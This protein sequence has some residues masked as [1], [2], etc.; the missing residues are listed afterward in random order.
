MAKR[1]KSAAGSTGLPSRED[2][3]AFVSG[4]KRKVGKREIARAFGVQSG[5][6]VWLRQMLRALEDEGVLDRRRKSVHAAGRLPPVVV[7]DITGRDR[8]GE[9]VAEPEEWDA[10]A[11][12]LSAEELRAGS[13]VEVLRVEA[14]KVERKRV[15]IE[16]ETVEE[17]AAK[18]AEAIVAEGVLEG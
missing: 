1:P 12:G 10:A 2:V 11:L 13:S 6:R 9:L 3:V 8:D 5:D 14:P 18:L 7:A 4:A 17:A 16:A 15:V